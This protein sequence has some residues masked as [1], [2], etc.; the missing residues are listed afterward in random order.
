[1]LFVKSRVRYIENLDVTN[2]RG[3]E[4]TVRYIEVIVNDDNPHDINAVAVKLTQDQGGTLQIVGNV[5][6]TLSRVF[7]LFLK[8]GGQILVEVTG[9]RRNKGI[10]IESPAPGGGGGYSSEF[11][12]GVSSNPDPISDLNMPFSTPVFRPDL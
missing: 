4:Q 6:L 10:G 5:P 11:L 1:M 12:V 7:H 2:L 3:N 9:K 8:H